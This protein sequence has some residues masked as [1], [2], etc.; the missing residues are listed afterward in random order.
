MI[1]C[2]D[3]TSLKTDPQRVQKDVNLKDLLLNH[4]RYYD[5]T[6]DAYKDKYVPLDFCMSVRSL[7][8]NL[9]LEIDGKDK[10][11]YYR[12][13][14]SVP[15]V[16]HKGYDLVM[17]MTGLGL[18]YDIVYRQ[19]CDEIMMKHSQFQCIGLYNM[20]TDL[21]NPIIYSQVLLS[22]EGVDKMKPYLKDGRRF[23]PISS[24]QKKGNI[25]PIL[26]TL[27]EV[28]PKKESDDNE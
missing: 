2:I 16:I 3:T 27:I 9:V 8:T 25:I 4:T 18:M 20:N 22:D 1:L 23:V 24:M 14:T 19:G 5:S 11:L 21:M 13:M 26:D 10:K 17:Y 28:K 15:E 7:Y 12:N 6:E